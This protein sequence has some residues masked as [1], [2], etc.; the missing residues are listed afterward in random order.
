MVAQADDAMREA[1]APLLEPSDQA[2]TTRA[3]SDGHVGPSAPGAATLSPA[4]ST[5]LGGH[6]EPAAFGD[7]ATPQHSPRLQAV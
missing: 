1:L 2:A 7:S 6:A 3:R 5:P 4:M